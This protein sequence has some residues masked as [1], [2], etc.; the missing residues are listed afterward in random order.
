M[1]GFSCGHIQLYQNEQTLDGILLPLRTAIR[2]N[3]ALHKNCTENKG[4]INLDC[5]F[6]RFMNIIVFH[7]G[8]KLPSNVSI[9]LT[10]FPYCLVDGRFAIFSRVFPTVEWFFK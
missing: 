10:L 3:P 4:K 7:Q 1:H 5:T 8:S 6:L 2:S 9:F